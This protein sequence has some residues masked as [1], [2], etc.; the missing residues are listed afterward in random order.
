MPDSASS[1]TRRRFLRESTAE[2]TLDNPDHR[3]YMVSETQTLLRRLT[4]NRNETDSP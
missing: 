2:E 4:M 3:E 1:T